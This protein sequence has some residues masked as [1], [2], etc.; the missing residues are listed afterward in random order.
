MNEKP[1]V[2]VARF[3]SPLARD[4]F[5]IGAEAGLNLKKQVYDAQRQ[6]SDEDDELR[7]EGRT[8]PRRPD[9]DE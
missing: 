9:R 2:T 1:K 6:K 5:A 4:L 3:S 8:Y 7:T